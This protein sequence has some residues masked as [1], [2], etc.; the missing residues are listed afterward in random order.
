M[1]KECLQPTKRPCLCA[2]GKR[3]RAA[4]QIF[5]DPPRELRVVRLPR[6][7]LVIIR[8]PRRHRRAESG[9]VPDAQRRVRRR[10]VRRGSRAVE[11][12]P[13][14]VRTDRQRPRTSSPLVRVRDR[15]LDVPYVLVRRVP[16]E[17]G[18]TEQVHVLARRRV[19]VARARDGEVANSA[20][21][22]VRPDRLREVRVEQHPLLRAQL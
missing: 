17:V 1:M 3:L 19:A 16:A 10:R 7:R 20:V 14:R 5:F 6:V 2:R 22:V 21:H 8:P 18:V 13:A 4:P 9:A 12:R 15:R 11:H